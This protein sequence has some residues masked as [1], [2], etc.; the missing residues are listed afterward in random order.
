MPSSE[1]ER[2]A[3]DWLDRHGDNAVALA[4]DMVAELEESGNVASAE[5]WRRVI[6]AIEELR[7]PERK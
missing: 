7:Q 2:L 1:V 6:A 4:R 5:M 3:R